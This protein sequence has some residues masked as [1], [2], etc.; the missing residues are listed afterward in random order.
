VNSCYRPIV[1]TVVVVVAVG[2]VVVVANVVLVDG[3]DAIVDVVVDAVVVAVADVGST[4]DCRPENDKSLA[5]EGIPNHPTK[6]VDD[7]NLEYVVD[8]VVG[9][10]AAY[11]EADWRRESDGDWR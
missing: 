2:Y 11:R 10:S 8:D 7:E 6:N 5:V 9:W 3:R 4:E 1:A